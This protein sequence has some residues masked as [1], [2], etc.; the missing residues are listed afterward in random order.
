MNLLLALLLIFSS[1]SDKIKIIEPWMRVGAQGQATGLFFKIENNSDK[2]DTLYKVEFAPA[3]LVQI[4]ETYDAGND[5]MGMREIGHLV[6]PAKSTVELK[7]GS[8][9]VMLMKLKK[10]IKKGYVG[11]CTLYFKGAGKIVIKA[12]A[13][14]MMNKQM[15]EHK[16]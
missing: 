12:E 1:P 13:K 3:G 11:E 6:I 15:M 8:Y 9:H 4:H 14:E 5:M 7:P 2:A 16:H 10:D